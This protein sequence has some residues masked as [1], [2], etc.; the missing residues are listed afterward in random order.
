MKVAVIQPY[1]SFDAKDTES[2]YRRQVELLDKCDE[3]MDIIVLPENAD[4]PAWQPDAE[5]YYAMIDKYNADIMFFSAAAL[6]ADGIISDWSE[7][8]AMLRIEMAKCSRKKVLLCDSSKFE[9]TSTFKLFKLSPISV[10]FCDTLRERIFERT[11]EMTKDTTSTT[12]SS[13]TRAVM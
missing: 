7:D 10:T 11:K 8:E 3:S 5:S 12:M 13:G 2:C 6:S 1:Y 9:K 4:V